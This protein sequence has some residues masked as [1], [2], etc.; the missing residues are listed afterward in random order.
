[1]TA[2]GAVLGAIPNG[3][4]YVSPQDQSTAL[5]AVPFKTHARRPQC[6]A[7]H[8]CLCVRLCQR[9]DL[10]CP[11]EL[12]LH[13]EPAAELGSSLITGLHYTTIS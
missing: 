12:K 6:A 7:A 3:P 10:P 11:I 13:G 4:V 2:P 5:F 9:G 1:M 8:I